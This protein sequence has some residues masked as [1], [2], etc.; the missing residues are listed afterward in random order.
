MPGVRRAMT[1]RSTPSASGLSASVHREDALAAFEIGPVDDDLAVEPAGPQQRGVEHVGPV[2]RRDQDHAGAH[3][4]AV[5]LDEQLVQRLLAFVV[6]A[7]DAGAPLA[8]DRVDLVDEHDRACPQPCAFLNR[9]RTRAAPM[10]A[11][12]S[13]KSLPDIEKN[14][15]PASPATARASSVFPV[16][17]G[18]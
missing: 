14:G 8:A 3:V 18:P 5:E 10:P 16:P 2:R 4:E 6:P 12:I 7:A 11:N 13:T 17:G 1:S 9:S 15:T